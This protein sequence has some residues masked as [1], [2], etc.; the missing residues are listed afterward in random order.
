[1]EK[2]YE[3]EECDCGHTSPI[4]FNLHDEDGNATCPN[5]VIDFIKTKR[6]SKSFKYVIL[7]RK[8][9]SDQS[10]NYV[11]DFCNGIDTAKEIAENEM[12]ERGGKYGMCVF[13]KSNEVEIECV[14][15]IKSPYKQKVNI[16]TDKA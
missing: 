7:A 14:F 6:I 11:V 4:E 16:P 10:H 8:W 15:E 12:R 3:I 2:T 1:M 9:S 13:G 5:C